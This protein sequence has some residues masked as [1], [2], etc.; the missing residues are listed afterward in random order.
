MTQKP[1]PQ[2]VTFRDTSV[3]AWLAERTN[4][5]GGDVTALVLYEGDRVATATRWSTMPREDRRRKCLAALRDRNAAVLSDLLISYMRLRGRQ[6]NNICP[7]TERSYISAIRGLVSVSERQGLSLV[8]PSEDFAA[9]CMRALEQQGMKAATVRHRA[10]VWKHL[11]RAAN[12]CGL[13]IPNPWEH[14]AMPRERDATIRQPYS[15]AEV[16]QLLTFPDPSIQ[17]TILLGAHGG[18]RASEIV[19][20]RRADVDFIREQVVVVKGK[21]GKSR[22]VPMTEPLKAALLALP[23]RN[24]L[25][26]IWARYITLY[27]TLKK[28]AGFTRVEWRGIHALRHTAGT[29]LYRATGDLYVTAELLGH[30]DVN[31]TKI[32]AH[33]AQDHLRAALKKRAG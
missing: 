25:T 19:N 10:S 4:E 18:L 20:L 24:G 8:Q 15:E 5:G 29:E 27:E 32:Y 21:G 11:F 33:M 28:V 16:A 1:R 23:E 14:T 12:W 13:T 9:L 31:T 30:S 2:P 6:G 26:L 17:A 22:V 7:T 3:E